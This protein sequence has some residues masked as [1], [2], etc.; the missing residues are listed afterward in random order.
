MTFMFTMFELGKHRK[1]KK[2]MKKMD[3]QKIILMFLAA[4]SFILFTNNT[5]SLKITHNKWFLFSFINGFQN[6]F[7]NEVRLFCLCLNNHFFAT[8]STSTKKT[9]RIYEESLFFVCVTI[10][11]NYAYFQPIS[12]CPFGHKETL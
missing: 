11:L 3:R 10:S 4:A 8:I 2:R 5:S 1:E 6:R 7:H 12:P 9:L